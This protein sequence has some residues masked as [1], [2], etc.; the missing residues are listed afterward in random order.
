M[1]RPKFLLFCLDVVLVFLS[2]HFGNLLQFGSW[3]G[4]STAVAP[5]VIR[6][7][8]LL[9]FLLPASYFFEL[10]EWRKFFY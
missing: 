2:L 6:L 4:E 3:T 1:I 5:D 9:L 7:L 8:V 10:Y